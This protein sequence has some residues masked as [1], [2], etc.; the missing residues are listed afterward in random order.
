MS[1][2]DL[3]GEVG[4]RGGCHRQDGAGY[5]QLTQASHQVAATLYQC[6]SG[7]LRRRRTPGADSGRTSPQEAVDDDVIDAEYVDVDAEDDK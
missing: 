5:E 4:S 6:G 3:G 2:G 1:T 7:G